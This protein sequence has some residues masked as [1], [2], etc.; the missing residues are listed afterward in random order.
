MSETKPKPIPPV[1]DP[2]VDLGEELHGIIGQTGGINA[3][4]GG[5]RIKVYH[6]RMFP[7]DEVFKTLLY[8]DFRIYVTRHKAD[9][10]IEATP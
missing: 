4:M 2:H 5:Y 7:W 6:T 10:Y 3:S 9:L 8:R 1:L